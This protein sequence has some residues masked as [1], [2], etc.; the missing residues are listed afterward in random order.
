M[1]HLFK[2]YLC[3]QYYISY[4]QIEKDIL[5][6]KKISRWVESSKCRYSDTWRKYFFLDRLT[7]TM[8]IVKEIAY[9]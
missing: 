5:H 8:Y 4:K 9:F 7:C 6:I 1:S 3:M 2:S